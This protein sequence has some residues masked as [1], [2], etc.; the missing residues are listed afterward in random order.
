MS[1]DDRAF[2]FHFSAPDRSEATFAALMK[3]AL[4]QLILL[5]GDVFPTCHCE[6]VLSESE[7][8]DQTVRDEGERTVSHTKIFCL[9]RVS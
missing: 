5:Y 3:A 1:S 4:L 2:R 7:H 8:I 6:D 9:Y